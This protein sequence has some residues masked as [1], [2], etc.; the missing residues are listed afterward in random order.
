MGVIRKIGDD[1]YIEFIARGLSYQRNGGGDKKRAEQLLKD[2]EG[3]IQKGEMSIVVN[4]I[5]GGQFFKDVLETLR[6]EQTTKT[7]SRYASVINLF[8]IYCAGALSANFKLSQVTPSVIEGYRA[9]LIN[10]AEGATKGFNFT[11]FLLKDI[12]DYAISLGYLNDNPTLHTRLIDVPN[13]K[14]PR[15]FSN[16]EIKKILLELT[17]QKRRVVQLLLNTGMALDELA[18]L[19][20]ANVD[21][22]D[23]CIEI[24]QTPKRQIPMNNET[25]DL[26]KHFDDKYEYVI[27]DPDG[28]PVANEQFLQEAKQV[29]KK[30][31]MNSTMFFGTLRHTFARSVLA[32]GVSLVRLSK[33]LGLR[34]IALVMKY[35]KFIDDKELCN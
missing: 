2:I 24:G 14:T 9:H 16:E 32:K 28:Q 13:Q 8:Q 12:F 25:S 10:E 19:K 35:V 34:D 20:W 1:Y 30:M 21:F 33:L 15:T 5:E 27:V 3:Q 29:A 7:T 26:L 4:D 23:H 17:G 11:L 18:R 31:N 6:H 22:K